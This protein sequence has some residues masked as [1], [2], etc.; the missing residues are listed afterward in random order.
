MEG[1]ER[2]GVLA[3]KAMGIVDRPRAWSGVIL[4]HIQ[5]NQHLYHE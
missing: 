1:V 4:A 3:A 5:Q 2:G